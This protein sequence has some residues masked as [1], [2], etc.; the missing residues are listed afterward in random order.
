PAAAVTSARAR[1]PAAPPPTP[2]RVALVAPWRDPTKWDEITIAGITFTG[3]VDV[4]GDALKPKADHRRSRGSNGR[5]HVA[6]GHDTVDFTVVLAAFPEDDEA[7]EDLHVQEMDAIYARLSD[8]SPTRQGGAA[9]PVAYPSLAFARISMATV[10]SITLPKFEAGGM[11]LM[12]IKFKAFKE[13]VPRTVRATTTPAE[14]QTPAAIGAN[15][16]GETM[17]PIDRGP[18]LPDPPSRSGAAAPR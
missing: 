12:T 7:I 6:A 11:L 16:R 8:E 2:A 15:N 3:K 13:P 17:V 10:E 14:S 9:F 5:R 4:D 18:R 1:R